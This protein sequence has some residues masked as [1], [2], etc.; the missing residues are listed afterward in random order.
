MFVRIREGQK[1]M[2]GRGEGR[3]LLLLLYYY[4]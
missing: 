4:Y 2:E 3:V 1:G